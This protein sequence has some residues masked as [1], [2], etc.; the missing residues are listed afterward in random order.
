MVGTLDTEQL[1]EESGMA[2]SRILPDRLYHINDSGN[3]P[4]VYV[5]NL[6][7]QVLQKVA[8]LG[9]DAKTLDFEAISVGPC[10]QGSCVYVADIGDNGYNRPELAV[11]VFPEQTLYPDQLQPQRLRLQ[12]PDQAQDAESMAMHPNGDL[13]IVSKAVRN[14]SVGV[15][16]IYRLPAAVLAQQLADSAPALQT[17]EKVADLD[18]A[19]YSTSLYEWFSTFATDMSISAD[20]KRLLLLT[21]QNAF[22]F[23]WDLAQTNPATVWTEGQNMRRI[24]LV[25]LDQ[26]ESVAYTPDGKG[27][28]YSTEYKVNPQNIMQ[29]QCKQ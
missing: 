4:M 15:T 7:G 6:A 12:Y 26:Q 8:L 22:E 14:W 13:Y 10:A 29:V 25:V 1:S 21:Y 24:G 27:F 11:W 16:R 19:K 17:L 28:V 23:D 3:A 18:L 2:F 20:G 9:V 5:S